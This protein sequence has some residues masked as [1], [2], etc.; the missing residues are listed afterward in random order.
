VD[1]ADFEKHLN[2]LAA[3]TDFRSDMRELLVDNDA[4][5]D[6]FDI[7]QIMSFKHSHVWGK[8]AK[9]ALVANSDLAY[10]L[11]RM[12]QLTA[13]GEHGEI[14][15]FRDINEARQWLGLSKEALINS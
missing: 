7:S 4:V 10:G 15:L 12:F 3:D 9:R 6:E 13:D 14:S 2:A 8:G 5:T 11:F 1:F